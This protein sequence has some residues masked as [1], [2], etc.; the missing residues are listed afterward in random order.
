VDSGILVLCFSK[1]IGSRKNID[2]LNYR[3]TGAVRA[4]FISL[5]TADAL[6]ATRK[7]LP[8]L[9]RGETQSDIEALKIPDF[10]RTWSFLT[11]LEFN[12]Q[13]AACPKFFDPKARRFL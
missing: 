4:A 6:N 3:R 7:T 12:W 2:I 11:K 9:P 5:L 1:N 10:Q 13:N 8:A